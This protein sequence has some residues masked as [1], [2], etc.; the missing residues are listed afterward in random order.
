MIFRTRFPKEKKWKNLLR[1]KVNYETNDKYREWITYLRSKWR[2]IIAIVCDW[3][4]WLLWWF[5]TIP[6]Q[7]CNYHMKQIT[8]RYLT[9]RPILEANISLKNIWMCIWDYTKDDVEFAL[10]IWYKDY[11]SWLNQRNENWNYIHIKTRKAYR[12]MKKKI[13]WCYIYKEYSELWIPNT[14]NSLES[15]N[16][17]LKTKLSIHRWISELRKDKFAGYYLWYS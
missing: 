16:S 2:I 9:K 15:I 6:T 8:T 1:Y 3:R 14:N 11:Y 12:S 4:Q 17:H 7:M 5:W 13:K 10:E